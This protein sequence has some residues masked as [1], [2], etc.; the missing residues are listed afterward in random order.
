MCGWWSRRS[1][2][3]EGVALFGASDD[4]HLIRCVPGDARDLFRVEAA[5]EHVRRPRAPRK[6]RVHDL[7]ARVRLP[8]DD[9]RVP[10]PA[11]GE[12]GLVDGVSASAERRLRPGRVYGMN[13]SPLPSVDGA[14]ETID[15]V[16]LSVLVATDSHLSSKR[17][18]ERP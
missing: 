10:P 13:A 11:V 12:N 8:L 7:V 9:V 3:A 4:V 1:P 2:P 15:L 17:H 6:L 14:E 5:L 18:S 16:P